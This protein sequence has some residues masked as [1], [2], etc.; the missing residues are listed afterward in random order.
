MNNA[1]SLAIGPTSQTI[2]NGATAAALDAQHVDT[3]QCWL[4][5]SRKHPTPMLFGA[6]LDSTTASGAGTGYCPIY[7]PVPPQTTHMRIA[8]LA[9]G[10]GTVTLTSGADAHAVAAEISQSDPSTTCTIEDAEVHWMGPPKATAAVVTD[11]DDRALE[12][13]QDDDYAWTMVTISIV[14]GVQACRVWGFMIDW[15]QLSDA[16]AMT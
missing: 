11:T 1:P 5:A 16:V 8:V 12:C 10:D 7:I 4:Y 2:R 6:P 3:C 9:T 13:G 14:D 15:Y